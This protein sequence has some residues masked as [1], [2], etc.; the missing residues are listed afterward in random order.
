MPEELIIDNKCIAGSEDIAEKLNKYFTSIADNWNQNDNEIPTSDTE[1][2]S[3]YVNNKIPNDTFFTIPFIIPEQVT[4]YINKL[5]CSKATGLDGIRPRILN[6][7]APAVFQSISRLINKSLS[8]GSFPPQLKQAK[9]LPIFK[10]GT[11]SDLSNYRPISILPT[12]SKIFE[13]HV[14]KHLMSFLNKYKLLHES[15]SGFRHKHSCQTALIKLIYSWMECIDSGDMLGALFIDFRKAIDLVDHT[16]LM[17]KLS[18]YK[19][20]PSTIQ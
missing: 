5:D 16:L 18:I 7:A 3:Q 8:T 13:K 19:F 12:I 6:I 14:N 11:K 10:D 2:I 4:N 9:V 15:Q 17:K 1:K 20:S